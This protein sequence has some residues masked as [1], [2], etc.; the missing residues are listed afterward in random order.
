MNGLRALAKLIPMNSIGV[1]VG[2][3][4]GE[5]MEI[6]MNSGRVAEMLCVDTWEGNC[7]ERE[8]WFDKRAA[9][10]PGRVHKAKAKSTYVAHGFTKVQFAFVY[11]DASHNYESVAADITAWMP[12]VRKGGLLCGHDYRND[13][14]RAVDK[15]LGGPDKIFE[16]S[17]WLKVITENPKSYGTT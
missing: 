7:A 5:S 13:V 14:K 8:H 9:Q 16:D 3:G 12:R 4:Y 17:S 1:E 2:S 11:I 6:F 15:L 10:W